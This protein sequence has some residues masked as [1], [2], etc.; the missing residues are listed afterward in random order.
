[1]LELHFHG[2]PF[3]TQKFEY[4]R[5]SV[6]DVELFQVEIDFSVVLDARKVKDVLDV[7]LDE[8]DALLNGVDE[9]DVV[10]LRR[11]FHH[12]A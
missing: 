8:L 9:L 1:V 3:H 10:S 7:Q 2:H 12:L 6:V 4:L 11:L 5:E